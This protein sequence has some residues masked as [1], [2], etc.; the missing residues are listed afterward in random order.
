[1][2]LN[3]HHRAFFTAS[4]P[5]SERHGDMLAEWARGG[6]SKPGVDA[7]HP[8]QDRKAQTVAEI[9]KALNGLPS[10]AARAAVSQKVFGVATR[11]EIEAQ[12][13]D[14]LDAALIPVAAGGPTKLEMAVNDWKTAN[15]A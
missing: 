9:V 8:S 1:M 2:K 4:E 15:A 6:V 11:A 7:P 5:I 12:T 14:K 3:E 10:N 13:Q